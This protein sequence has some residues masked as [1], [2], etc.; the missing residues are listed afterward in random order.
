M[1]RRHRA[2]YAINPNGLIRQSP[3]VHTYAPK[4]DGMT[5]KNHIVLNIWVKSQMFSSFN[6]VW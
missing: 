2:M 4:C 6:L 1:I 3:M 5:H